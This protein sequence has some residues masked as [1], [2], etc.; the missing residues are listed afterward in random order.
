MIGSD[1]LPLMRR[2]K[3]KGPACDYWVSLV[4]WVRHRP[5]KKL[6]VLSCQATLHTDTAHFGEYVSVKRI[7]Q[8]ARKKRRTK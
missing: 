5:R 8:I 4:L 7:K 6:G 2:I 1:V 3:V